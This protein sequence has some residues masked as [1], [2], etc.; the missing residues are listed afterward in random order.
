MYKRT[1]VTGDLKWHTLKGHSKTG[2]GENATKQGKAQEMCDGRMT[3][4]RSSK[5]ISLCFGSQKSEIAHVK[6][7]LKSSTHMRNVTCEKRLRKTGDEFPHVGI[8]SCSIP[9]TRKS[10]TFMVNLF[11]H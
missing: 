6:C 4:P 8:P 3:S 7:S 11:Q 1:V 5:K 10:Q 9:T 2:L